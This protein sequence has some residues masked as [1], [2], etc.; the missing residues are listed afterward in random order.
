MRGSARRPTPGPNQGRLRSPHRRVLAHAWRMRRHSTDRPTRKGRV[1]DHLRAPDQDRRARDRECSTSIPNTSSPRRPRAGAWPPSYIRASEAFDAQVL[2]D[3][4]E[5]QLSTCHRH[6]Y[7][8]Q[9]VSSGKANWLVR[10]TGSVDAV[11]RVWVG[12]HWSDCRAVSHAYFFGL[13]RLGGLA[14]ASVI[15][16]TVKGVDNSNTKDVVTVVA[17]E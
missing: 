11:P 12:R 14:N 13:G 5:E 4:L 9:M 1:R 10:T 15:C 3:P 7:R 16:S 6:R 8:A 17:R 2:L